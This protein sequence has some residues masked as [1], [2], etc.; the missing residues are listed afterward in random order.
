MTASWRRWMG[1]LV[2]VLAI[3]SCTKVYY[4]RAQP[5]STATASPTSPTPTP[6]VTADKIEYR[7]F[8]SV[9]AAPVQI[10]FT[11]TIDGLTVLS[12][13]SLP[14]VASVQSTSD[15]IFLYLEANALSGL[16]TGTL[17]VQIYVNGKLF[18]EGF[19]S[20]AASLTA[21]ASGTYRR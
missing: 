1:L 15:S 9:G 21:T 14:Y 2:A 6:T 16:L 3:T 7:V 13:A 17:Q 12:A 18:R 8:G 4:D 10:K 5:S 11:N 20:G 19:A